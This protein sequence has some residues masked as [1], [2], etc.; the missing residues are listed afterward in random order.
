MPLILRQALLSQKLILLITLICIPVSVSAQMF[1]FYLPWDD[2]SDTAV[3]LDELI[4]P[5]AGSE[6]FVIVD[7][8]AHLSVA[9]ERIKFWGVNVC[10]GAAFPLAGDAEKIA[11][12]MRKFGINLVRFHHMDTSD[13][14]VTTDPDRELDPVELDKL[15][16]FIYQLKQNGIY[17]NLNL[18][19]SR[20][21]NPGTELHPDIELIDHWKTRAS[22]GFFDPANTALQK[23]YAHDLLTHVNPYTGAAYVDE[24][25]FAFIE[26]NNENGLLHSFLSSRL[27]DLPPYYDG[28][29]NDVWNSWL[30]QKYGDH[31]SLFNA[32]EASDEPLGDEALIN[33][34]FASGDFSPWILA[35]HGEA[36]AECSIETGAGP[37]GRNA[38]RID[39]TAASSAGWHVQFLQG[40]LGMPEG[41]PYTLT[42]YIKSSESRTIYV[43]IN[44]AH[45]PWSN[46]GF[47]VAVDAETSWQEYSYTF[48]LDSADSNAGVYFTNMG[49]QTG[50]VYLTGISLKPGGLFGFYPG[51]NLD[52][53]TIR[54]FKSFGD[55]PR[56]D[57][58]WR[59]WYRF[60]TEKEENYFIGMRDYIKNELG[61]QSLITGTIIGCSN[62]NV[63]ANF[64]FVD[65][66]AYWS[67]AYSTGGSDP[68]SW[69]IV[70]ESMINEP[71]GSAVV[72]LAMKNILSMPHSVSEYNHL[73]PNTFQAEAFL[74]LSIY[75][76]FHD[77]DVLTPFAYSHRRDDW[78][79]QRC[80]WFYE[81]DQNPV[82][83]AS[84]IPAARTFLQGDITPAEHTVVGSLDREAEIE[85]VLNTNNWTVVDAQSAGVD[86]RAALIHKVELAVEGQ[87]VPPDSIA[88]GETD[89]SGNVFTSDTG[90]IVWDL[91]IPGR[92]VLTVNAAMTKMVV[93]YGESRCFDLS[94]V[95]VTV[96]EGM[97]NGFAVIALNTLDDNP[98]AQSS[99]MLVTA[100]GAVDNTGTTWYEYP[101]DTVIDFPPG[102]GIK[103]TL[104][105]NIGDA[106]SR[107]EGVSAVIIIPALRENTHVWALN[108]TG[109]R[110]IE[111]PLTENQNRTQFA[112]DPCY[113]VVWY[114]IDIDRPASPTPTPGSPPTVPLNTSS[115]ILLAVFFAFVL[116]MKWKRTEVDG[117]DGRDPRDL[118]DL[119][120]LRDGRD[121]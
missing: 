86:P 25:C 8:A 41:M 45:E 93:G 27:D 74:F 36:E 12:R 65:T 92:G 32:W 17:S 103:A 43:T 105:E 108:N 63:Q 28:M 83:M 21:F 117:R 118:R 23:Q 49:L 78:D 99:A 97:Q 66:H 60:L 42:F 1:D 121:F 10:N 52:D 19:V 84:F 112:V 11:Q 18:L 70:N 31:D 24:P 14:W 35:E 73:H 59:D 75:G 47:K 98:F 38:L 113:N 91:S 88:P 89:V 69:Y 111:L 64:D 3:S 6:G 71:V 82:K 114:E 61:A 40:N 46:L 115:I 77:F 54:N 29:L 87:T 2:A 76:S 33:G 81:F 67:P 102:E 56:T 100:L 110:T 95:T 51:E 57:E 96:N 53:E 101:A 79:I 50:S 106:P 39:I 116:R 37:E 104:K 44:M 15:D 9:G 48:T 72:S 62:P 90:E 22:L 16:Y 120:D 80:D 34:D 4:P 7:E 13:I 109:E 68:S 30:T 94:N 119:R 5:D 20:P 26:I 55:C 58:G 85:A 107:V